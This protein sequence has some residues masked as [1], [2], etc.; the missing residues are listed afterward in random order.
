[1][2]AVRQC[3]LAH[4]TAYRV[5]FLGRDRGRAHGRSVRVWVRVISLGSA[6]MVREICLTEVHISL[7]VIPQV[8]PTKRG[9]T[10][11]ARI[12]VPNGA[13]NLTALEEPEVGAMQ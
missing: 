5:D 4:F 12:R 13:K 11:C 2:N 9:S 3:C 8:V 6:E 10:L 7:C 1:M